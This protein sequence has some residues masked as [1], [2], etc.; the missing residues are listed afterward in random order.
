MSHNQIVFNQF[1]DILQSLYF[2]NYF[3]YKLINI[4]AN[5]KLLLTLIC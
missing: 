1:I 4:A 2:I 5:Q 3:L